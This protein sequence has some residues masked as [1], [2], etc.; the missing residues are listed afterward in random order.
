MKMRFDSDKAWKFLRENGFVVTLR[1]HRDGRG[2]I[3]SAPSVIPV[4][5]WRGG[6]YTGK[7]ANKVFI[8][9]CSLFESPDWLDDEA[10][11]SGFNDSGEWL[12]EAERLSGRHESWD[13]FYV[14]FLPVS[15]PKVGK[16]IPSDPYNC[17]KHGFLTDD[18]KKA[19]KHI[20]GDMVDMVF[21]LGAKVLKAR[22]GIPATETLCQC[23]A[24]PFPHKH[25]P[26]PPS[27]TYAPPGSMI[28]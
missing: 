5:I 11:Y 22:L 15:S 28:K 1:E 25:A 16:M 10:R 6:E 7:N 2:V 20:Q 27:F 26:V 21:G 3:L 8:G 19:V 17:Q 18:P 12:A 4:E 24:L 13:A 9:T 23:G 14:H